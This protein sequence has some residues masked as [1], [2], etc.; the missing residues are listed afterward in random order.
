MTRLALPIALVALLAPIVL[1]FVCRKRRRAMRP[2]I[3]FS[4]GQLVTDIRPTLRQRLLWTPMFLRLAT[5]TLLVVAIA[6]PQAGFGVVQTSA[7]AVAIEIVVDRSSSMSEPMM[8]RGRRVSRYEVVKRLFHDFVLGDGRDLP[9]RPYD[10][11]GLVSFARYAE[12]VCPL[13]RAHDALASLMDSTDL[14]TFREEDGTAI[15]D[16][17]ALAAARLRTAEQDLAK[18]RAT[19]LEQENNSGAPTDLPTIKSKII[20]LLTD[21]QNNAGDM[22]PAA[23]AKL[24]ADWGIKIYAI[25]IGADPRSVSSSPMDLFARA[26]RGGVDTDTLRKLA[27]ITDGKSWIA[28]SASALR[29]AYDQIDQ[30]EK[31]NIRSVQYTN[32]DE[33]FA[34]FAIVALVALALEMLLAST[35]LRR[36]P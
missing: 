36:S 11:I 4:S 21:G 14:V 13:T 19:A 9:G 31:T 7:D 10:P 24:A 35:L 30:L 22:T 29:Q 33:R 25:G 6:R 12:T 3:L 20:I 23:A 28:S 2:A 18:Q 8:Y 27:E 17:V 34:P 5:L 32:Y 1:L 15:G 26:R 16:A